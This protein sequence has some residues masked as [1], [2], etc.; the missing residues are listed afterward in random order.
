M[1]ATAAFFCVL[2]GATISVEY[3]Q[4]RYWTKP[5]MVPKPFSIAVSAPL[6]KLLH[7]QENFQWLD[8]SDTQA[9]T[10]TLQT[11]LNMSGGQWT[12]LFVVVRA[13]GT[14]IACVILQFWKDEVI[15]LEAAIDLL[16]AARTMLT[17]P[18]QFLYQ[19]RM[20]KM[21]VDPIYRSRDTKCDEKLAFVIMP[22][23]VKWSDRIWTRIVRPLIESEGLQ[24]KRADD[25]YGRDI[26][27]DIWINILQS[28]FVVA[29]V[30]GRNANVFYEL[31]LAHA[32]RKPVILLTQSIAD[33]PFDLNRYHHIVY[34]DNLDGYDVLNQ[35]LKASIREL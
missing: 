30:T 10:P 9:L 5:T 15:F 22:F 6:L 8:L 35:K 21:I 31:G 34:E 4:K 13:A 16:K 7:S 32:I 19:R 18:A 33:I 12:Y 17:L 24:P 1:A 14:P 20:K 26:M 11:L 29:D 25:L 28:R 27:E 23:T 3:F 2:D